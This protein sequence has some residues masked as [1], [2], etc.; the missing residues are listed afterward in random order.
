MSL[1]TSKTAIEELLEAYSLALKAAN[2]RMLGSLY[3]ADGLFMPDRA[4]PLKGTAEIENA[5]Q[6]YL[7]QKQVHIK[8]TVTDLVLKEP[9][10]FVQA[11]STCAVQSLT[12]GKVVNKNGKDFFVLCKKMQAWKVY[13]YMFNA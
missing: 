9:F 7:A 8:F 4:R 6:K 3:A 10:A 11:T 1:Q 2:A 5:A 12:T 13:R